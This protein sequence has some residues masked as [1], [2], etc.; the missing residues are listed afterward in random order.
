VR[1]QVGNGQSWRGRL[2]DKGGG[3]EV[4]VEGEA[5]ADMPRTGG[6]LS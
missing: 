4:E 3:G 5:K 1:Q 2:V 6:E